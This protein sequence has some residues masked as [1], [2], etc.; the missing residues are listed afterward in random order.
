MNP[1]EMLK[2]IDIARFYQ[3]GLIDIQFANFGQSVVLEFCADDG[4]SLGYLVCHDVLRFHYIDPNFQ[5]GK[6]T[7]IIQ[8]FSH[9]VHDI[10]LNMIQ[11]DDNQ[12]YHLSLR[13]YVMLD[14]GCRDVEILP[15]T[16]I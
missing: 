4:Q 11:C 10:Q 16:E 5:H 15:P 8:G 7:E 3:S 2:N 1:N 14:I 9:Y 12:H 6:T 13:P